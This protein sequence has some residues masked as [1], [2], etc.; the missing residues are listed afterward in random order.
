VVTAP[1]NC[2]SLAEAGGAAVGAG[3]GVGAGDAAST[4]DVATTPAAMMISAIAVNV[5]MGREFRFGLPSPPR[6]WSGILADLRLRTR[7][8]ANSVASAAV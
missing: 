4:G 3:V 1:T 7:S 2:V 6:R 5:R 8:C